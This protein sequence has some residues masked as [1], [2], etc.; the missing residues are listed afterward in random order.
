VRRGKNPLYKIAREFGITHTQL[1]RIRKG[2][3]WGHVTIDD[4]D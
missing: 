4:E 2:E 1:N 3:N